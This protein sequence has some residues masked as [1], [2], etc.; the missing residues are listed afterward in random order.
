[1]AAEIPKTMEGVVINKTGGTEVLEYKTD[2]PVPTPGEGQILVKNEFTGINYI[3]TYFRTG[4]YPVPTGFPYILG[5]E[6]SGIVQAIG[7]GNT[8]GFSVGDRVVYLNQHTYAQYTAADARMAYKLPN[9]ISN[10]LATAAMLQGLT[11]LTM[12]RESHPVKK[13]EWILVHAAA[14]GVGLLLVQMLKAVGAK[15]IATCST[16]KLDQVRKYN[17]DVLIDYTTEDWVAKVKE[18]TGGAGV[19]AVFDGVGKAT[20]DGSLESLARKG[21]MVSFG[22][23]SGAVPPFT[24]ARLS[25]KNLKLLRPMLFAYL[26]TR[27]EFDAYAKELF[28]QF[29]L[30]DKMDVKIHDIYPLKEVARA[31]EDIQSR[32]TSG[33]LLLRI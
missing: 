16:S 11:A 8:Y 1:M 33:K 14:G 30:K 21:T 28:E 17:P 19:A 13:G 12:I 22:N 7:S 18:A 2:L 31:H 15:L 23:A 6:S 5:R 25:P 4:L 20:F 29:I 9:E 27:E 26:A 3:D 32:K 24:I 10:E